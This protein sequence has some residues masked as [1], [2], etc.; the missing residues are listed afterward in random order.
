M[1]SNKNSSLKFI[2]IIA[3]T[4]IILLIISILAFSNWR[5]Y[6]F[7][8]PE[9]TIR[10]YYEKVL[11]I[12]PFYI[13]CTTSRFPQLRIQQSLMWNKRNKK[14]TKGVNVSYSRVMI[15]GNTAKATVYVNVDNKQELH[16][17]ELV[18]LKDKTVTFLGKYLGE[19]KIDTIFI[20]S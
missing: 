5:Y 19:W 16:T 2:P 18:K 6:Y 17:L 8:Q 14:Q 7:Y 3:V 10:A 13:E 4:L 15:L 1:K 12:D 11:S 9:N 20:Q